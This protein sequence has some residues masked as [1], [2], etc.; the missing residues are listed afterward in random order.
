MGRVPV[1]QAQVELVAVS[2]EG[3]SYMREDWF[4]NLKDIGSS[5]PSG[6]G[7]GLSE[8]AKIA[9]GV[10]ASVVVTAAI[11]AGGFFYWHRNRGGHSTQH[12]ITS[13]AGSSNWFGTVAHGR[14]HQYVMSDYSR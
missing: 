1:D 12:D 8:G 7:G 14:T 5:S 4:G 10:L 9:I 13:Q 11:L 2:S 3:E 6:G